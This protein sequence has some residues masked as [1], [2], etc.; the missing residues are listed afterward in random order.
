MRPIN[1]FLKPFCAIVAFI[2]L[3]AH[4][5]A[6]QN[7]IGFHFCNSSQMD[8]TDQAGAIVSAANWNNVKNLQAGDPLVMNTIVDK[9]G[10]TVD[11]MAFIAIGGSSPTGKTS[12]ATPAAGKND[13]RLFNSYFDQNQGAESIIIVTKIPFSHYDVYFYRRD[14]GDQ[15]AGKFKVG[16]AELYLHDGS[17]NPTEDGRGYVRSLTATASGDA[18]ITAGNYVVFENL[19]GSTLHA[20]FSAAKAGDNTLRSKVV[21]FQIVERK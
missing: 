10:K 8:S 5:G 18:G 2:V 14:D 12:D 3:C 20:T 11:G 15:R 9:D 4:H 1:D 13:A 6:A 17:G 21:G 19:S 16:S 7:A